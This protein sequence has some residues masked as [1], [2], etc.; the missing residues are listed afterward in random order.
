MSKVKNII[1]G[2][3]CVE[4]MGENEHGESVEFV[5]VV[6]TRNRII[7]V[8]GRNVH[9]VRTWKGGADRY[10]LIFYDTTKRHQTPIIQS[11]VDLSYADE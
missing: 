4:G 1:L 3:L 11:G 2:E 9:W 10:S 6:E 5:N 7:K 8:D